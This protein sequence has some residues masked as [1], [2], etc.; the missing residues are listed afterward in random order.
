MEKVTDALHT[1]MKLSQKKIHKKFQMN[2][3]LFSSKCTK[4][5]MTEFQD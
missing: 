4:L 1:R 3:K 5:N 2:E